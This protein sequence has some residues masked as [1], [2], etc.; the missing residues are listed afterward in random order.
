MIRKGTFKNLSKNNLRGPRRFKKNHKE[1]PNV[2]ELPR[3]LFLDTPLGWRENL[4]LFLNR[5]KLKNVSKIENSS[6]I[7]IKNGNFWN[8]L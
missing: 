7:D 4:S 1:D 6:K 3:N 8:F 5:K 2:F